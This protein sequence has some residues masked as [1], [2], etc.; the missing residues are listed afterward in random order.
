MKLFYSPASPYVRKVMAVAHEAGCAGDIECLPSAAHPVNRDARIA[1]SSPLAKVPTAVLEDGQVLFDS[2]VIC[3]YLAERYGS[4]ALFPSG[5]ARWAVLS[6]QALGDGLLDAA[7]L[8]RYE[9]A[10]RPAEFQWQPWYDGQI[11]KVQAS[12]DA[13]EAIAAELPTSAPDIGAITLGCALGY[14]DFRFADLDWRAEHPRTAAWFAA[15]DEL[16]AMRETR[17]RDAG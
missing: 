11:T 10:A 5:A 8:A 4:P 2:R 17:P 16:P 14:L 7:L 3:E 15:F 6:R 12:V 13:I 1:A 9:R